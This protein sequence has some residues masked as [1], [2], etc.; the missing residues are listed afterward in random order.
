MMFN[1]TTVTWLVD[2]YSPNWPLRAFRRIV[3][4]K[5]SQKAA[6]AASRRGMS[7][8][9]LSEKARVLQA[10][11]CALSTVTA[12]SGT[13]S[14]K[15]AQ[16]GRCRIIRVS[17][18]SSA[19]DASA[20]KW[21]HRRHKPLRFKWHVVSRFADMTPMSIPAR[22]GIS[23]RHRRQLTSTSPDRC[24]CFVINAR[25]KRWAF[26]SMSTTARR[27]N[28]STAAAIAPRS[29]RIARRTVR[30]FNAWPADASS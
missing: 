26:T 9:I 3:N 10:L 21:A 27:I 13:A 29:R 25:W 22:H 5:P 23:P 16:R 28:Q 18:F 2:E 19:A 24:G 11:R 30:H 4:L 6:C 17:S 12:S 14:R 8:I 15:F 7:A 20:G 1:S